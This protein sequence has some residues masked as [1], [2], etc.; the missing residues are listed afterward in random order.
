M[1][2][3]KIVINAE[4]A[5]KRF[6]LD[7][8]WRYREL[9][10]MMMTRDIKVRYKQTV[11]GVAW[12]VIQPLVSMLIFTVIFG[13]L[14]KIPSDGLPYPVFV[15]SGL[16]A[17]TFFSSAVTAGG[18]SMV[19]ASTMISKV[20][21]P[22]LVIPIASIGVS[23]VDFIISF[24]LLLLMMA[25]YSIAPSWQIVFLPLFIAGLLFA[26]LGMST[27]LA[28]I[29]V[30]YRDFRFVIPFMVQIWMYVTPVIYPLS[31]VPEKWRWVIYFNPIVGWVGGIRSA[32]LNQPIDWFGVVTSL[33]LTALIFVLG[34]RYFKRAE[35]RFADVI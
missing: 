24:A 17:W 23:V 4:S 34:L 35:R 28:A 7:E 25:F 26:A 13:R 10:F 16:I 32:L 9:V 12:A 3:K 30:V 29:T 15:F 33:I 18:N 22:R 19:G 5:H 2:Y 11:L 20:Y 1:N 27:W 8:L 6:N 14:A 31:F 21:F